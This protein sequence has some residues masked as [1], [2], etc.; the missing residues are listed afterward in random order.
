MFFNP[1]SKTG[2]LRYRFS[3]FRILSKFSSVQIKGSL[4]LIS[5]Y[6][7]V[8]FTSPSD[9]VTIIHTSIVI[10]ALLSRIIFKE[11]LTMAHLVAVILSFIGVTLISKPAFLFPKKSLVTATQ[12]QQVNQNC[13]D[14]ILANNYTLSDECLQYFVNV[15]M[16]ASAVAPGTSIKVYLGVALSFFSAT[17]ISCVFCLIK[18]LNNS[19]VHWAT[20]SIYVCWFGIPFAATICA[21]LVKLR[22]SHTNFAQENRDLPMDVFYS[23]LSACVSLAGQI[24]LNISLQYEEATKI[25]IAKTVDVLFS[26][27]LQYFLLDIS[28]DLLNMLGAGSILLGTS[29]V[30][31]F[32]IF[33]NRYEAAKLAKEERDKNMSVVVNTI[34]ANSDQSPIVQDNAQAKLD[35]AAKTESKWSAMKN[36]VLKVI[37]VKI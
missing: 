15:S 21:V 17:A 31:I 36:L 28:M 32:R 13:T 3:N 8:I 12:A 2:G 26:A 35:A 7:A 6:F 34:H 19:K 30:L 24:M 25:A 23:V 16:N 9:V 4:A 20:S 22:V 5:S 1:G 29:F 33:E 14:P 11:K 37:F 27:V 18:K 10:T